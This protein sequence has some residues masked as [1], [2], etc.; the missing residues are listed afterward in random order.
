MESYKIEFTK[1]QVTPYHTDLFIFWYTSW[2]GESL[3]NIEKCLDIKAA[4]VKYELTNL[5]CLGQIPKITFVRDSKVEMVEKFVKAFD[6]IQGKI[7]CGAILK[8]KYLVPK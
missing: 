5:Q 8:L 1:V 6:I 3:E 7:V 4:D 2:K